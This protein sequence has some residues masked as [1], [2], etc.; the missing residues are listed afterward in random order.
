MMSSLNLLGSAS[1]AQRGKPAF[2]SEFERFV[3]RNFH[4]LERMIRFDLLF[5][6]RLDLFE[7]VRR[8]AV[9]KIDIVIKAVLHRRPGGELRFRPNSSKS[10]SQVRATPS[11]EDVRRSVIV[12]ALI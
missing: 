3:A 12:R 5:H 7:I 9:R 4:L 10:L 1:F 11:D 6:L 8:N 2:L